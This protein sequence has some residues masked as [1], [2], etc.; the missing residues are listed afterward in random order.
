MSDEMET[1]PVIP[2]SDFDHHSTEH[3]ADPSASYER[4]R[5][6]SG[7]V[8]TSAHGGYWVFTRYADIASAGKDHASLSSALQFEG[9]EEIGGGITLPHNPAATRMSLAE[10]DPPEWNHVR[11]ALNP[12]LSPHA[13]EQFVPRIREITTFFID[14]FIETGRCDLVTD[15]CS[16]IPAVV[17]LMYLG[18]PTHEWERFAIPI[19]SSVYTPREPGHP[20]FEHLLAAFAWIFSTIRKEIALRREAPRDD[21]ISSLLTCDIDGVP[22]DDELIFETVYTMLAAGVDTTTSLLSAAF[23]HL[24]TQTEDLERLRD[25]PSLLDTACEEFLRFYSP[26]QAGARTVRTDV[27]LGGVELQR[28]DRVLLAWASA[29]RDETVFEDPDTFVVDRSPNR[30]VAFGVGIHRCIGAP[31]AR[32]EFK[33]IVEEVLRRLPDLSID[34]AVTPRYPD[35]GL[36]FGYQQMPTTFT[37]GQREGGSVVPI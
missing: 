15:I 24:S 27:T 23:L 2:D 37:P 6:R 9:S 36:M 32:Q 31:L 17:T 13:V 7:V 16:P 12:T 22:Y 3:A 11:R 19:H 35:V 25:D 21:F 1:R 18:L 20:E 14:R 28:G 29:N 8:R 4:I 30:H 26:A 10:M 5:R 34:V 33:V